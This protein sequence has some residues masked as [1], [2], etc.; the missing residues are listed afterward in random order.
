VSREAELRQEIAQTEARLAALRAE[1]ALE[2]GTGRAERCA[3]ALRGRFYFDRTAGKGGG[4]WRR[5]GEHDL[6]VW[7]RCA[8]VEEEAR[9]FLLRHEGVVLTQAEGRS[10][11]KRL[12]TLLARRGAVEPERRHQMAKMMRLVRDTSEEFQEYW[13][14][15]LE[16][17]SR[18]LDGKNGDY[19]PDDERRDDLNRLIKAAE[20]DIA[21]HWA[22]ALTP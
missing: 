15:D 3:Q 13:R 14:D 22:P 7:A 4:R 12:Q 18:A 10:L 16:F 5:E 11:E 2:E 6:S 21:G 17:V 9:N 8:E 19:A 1:L 20:V